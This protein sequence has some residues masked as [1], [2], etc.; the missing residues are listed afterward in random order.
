VPDYYY[1]A[2]AFEKA[3]TYQML[4]LLDLSA[5]F[6]R[7]W[8]PWMTPG[9]HTRVADGAK[10]V[11]RAKTKAD[12][13]EAQRARDIVRYCAWRFVAEVDGWNLFC[14]DMHVDPEVLLRGMIG[15]DIV[16]RTERE[17]RT[18]A[19]TADEAARFVR[20]ATVGG[21][22]GDSEGS[23]TV[24]TPAGL[25]KSWHGFMDKLLEVGA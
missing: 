21:M 20:R 18:L 19:F 12:R 11:A 23:A 3:A 2:K 7:W 9:L 15:W 4:T 24:E 13:A 1:L 25:A 6:C 16:T 5:A 10:K 8:R 14:A 22:G 17:A